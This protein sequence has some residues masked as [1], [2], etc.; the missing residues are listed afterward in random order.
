VQIQ[1]NLVARCMEYGIPYAMH[2][3]WFSHRDMTETWFW[4]LREFQ[5]PSLCKIIRYSPL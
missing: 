5:G 2:P 4:Y 1:Y 3:K